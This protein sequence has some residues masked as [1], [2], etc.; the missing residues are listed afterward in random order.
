MITPYDKNFKRI[1]VKVSDVIAKQYVNLGKI[2]PDTVDVVLGSNNN[3]VLGDY[4]LI[5]VSEFNQF[6]YP[7]SEIG[8]V[9]LSWKYGYSLGDLLSAYDFEYFNVLC[10]LV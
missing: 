8:D 5:S 9:I 6:E 4:T 3:I 2:I 7:E 10:L 1:D